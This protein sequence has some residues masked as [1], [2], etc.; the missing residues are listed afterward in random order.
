MTQS[1]TKAQRPKFK[2]TLQTELSIPRFVSRNTTWKI[3][4]IW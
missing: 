3:S 1:K 4:L 2:H